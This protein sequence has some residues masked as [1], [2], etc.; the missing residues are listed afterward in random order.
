MDKKL[1]N[2]LVR[3]ERILNTLLNMPCSWIERP[4]DTIFP[5]LIY[6]FNTI[7][8]KVPG[9]FIIEIEVLIPKFTWKYKGPRRARVILRG[10][11]KLED[12]HYQISRLLIPILSKAG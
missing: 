12:L 6:S 2:I 5:K 8:M 1:L 9:D 3:N 10:R 4:K 7:L 11:T